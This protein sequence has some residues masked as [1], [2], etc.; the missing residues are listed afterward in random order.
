MAGPAQIASTQA[1]VDKRIRFVHA[2][3]SSGLRSWEAGRFDGIVSGL[4]IHYA[5]SYSHKLGRW[6]TEAYDRL[7]ATFRLTA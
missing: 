5:E 4:A 7:L 3:F 1:T 6:T 2:D